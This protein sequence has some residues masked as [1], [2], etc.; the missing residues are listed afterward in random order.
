MVNNPVESW[1]KIFLFWWRRLFRTPN[2][3][4]KTKIEQNGRLRCKENSQIFSKNDFP[5]PSSSMR[6]YPRLQRSNRRLNSSR[7]TSNSTSSSQSWSRLW[8]ISVPSQRDN[9][10]S[11]RILLKRIF[12]FWVNS[13]Y[14]RRRHSQPNQIATPPFPNRLGIPAASNRAES[15]IRP[16]DPAQLW[17]RQPW[18]PE[19]STELIRFSVEGA[20]VAASHGCPVEKVTVCPRFIWTAWSQKRRKHTWQRLQ[21]DSCE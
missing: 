13:N 17:W 3:N 7:L 20:T 16:W 6:A 19:K 14:C 21:T 12:D 18:S 2:Y 4:Q 9:N 1:R 5:S 8:M 15:G 10:V 11:Y